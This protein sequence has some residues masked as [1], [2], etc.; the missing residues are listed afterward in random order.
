MKRGSGKTLI[1][2]ALASMLFQKF[3]SERFEY[4][5]LPFG[6][7][8]P[9]DAQNAAAIA[10]TIFRHSQENEKRGIKTLIHLDNLEH[11]TP[12]SPAT[13]PLFANPQ[14]PYIVVG[15]LVAVLREYLHTIGTYSEHIAIVGES[16]I[17][18][19][20]L[21]EGVSRGFRK[22]AE[23]DRLTK[24]DRAEI[25]RIQLANSRRFAEGTGVDP[26]DPSID[27]RITELAT[28]A[29]GLNGFYIR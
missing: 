10:D 23:I 7:M 2:K 28:V 29:D 6:K 25:L 22:V 21:P 16:R 8:L 11:L 13:Q 14:Y 17:P 24:N 1:V 15:P 27:G 26:F 12:Y 18:R 4:F 19:E 20:M 5:R 3:G 9:K